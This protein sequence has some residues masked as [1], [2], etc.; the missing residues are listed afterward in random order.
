[1]STTGGQSVTQ[2][3]TGVWTVAADTGELAGEAHLSATLTLI[4]QS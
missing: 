1:M 3:P 2:L 4:K